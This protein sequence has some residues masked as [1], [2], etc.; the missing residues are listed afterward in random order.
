MKKLLLLCSVMLAA[1]SSLRAQDETPKPGTLKNPIVLEL[2]GEN[3][4]EF[5]GSYSTPVYKYT[6][7][8][9]QLVSVKP[10][11]TQ[12]S[13]K[14]TADGNAYGSQQLPS[15]KYDG[16]Y[17]FIV[18][19]DATVYLN[20]TTYSSPISLSASAKNHPYCLGINADEAIEIVADG[21]PMFVPFRE[22][23]YKE[24]PVYLKYAAAEDGALEMTFSGYVHEAY[25]AEGKNGKFS[26]ITCK[27]SGDNYRTFIPVEKGKEYFLRISSTSAKML[28]AELTHPVY[29]ES[30]D[31]P[32]VLTGTEA[33]I[34][35]KACKYYYEVTGT[36]SGY[37]VV[38]S[39]ISDFDGTVSWGRQVE[40]GLVTVDDG[41]FDLRQTATKGGHYFV[42]VD[43]KSDT[44]SPQ[45]FNVR[46]ETAQPYDSFYKGYEIA[47]GEE[48][49]LP[50]YP[51]TYFYRIKTPSEGAFIMKAAP[52]KA[53]T[54]TKS[55][56]RLFKAA[57]QSTPLYIG[58]PDIYCE[59]EAANEYI[60]QVTTVE[61]DKRNTLNVNLLDLQQGDGASNPFNV[62]IGGNN[63]PAG[64]A[65]YY[66]YK[67][68]KNSWVTVTPADMSINAPTVKRIKSELSSSEQNVTILRHGD[69]YRFEAETGHNYLLRFTK[70]KEATTFDFATPDYAQ[71]ESR[72]NPFEAEGSS[73]SIPAAPGV[74]WWSYTPARSGK[75]HISTDFKY[76]V[77]SSPTRENSVKLYSSETGYVLTTL[78]A[79]LT[80]ETF[81]PTTYNVD[82]GTKYLIQVSS[83]SEQSGKTVTLE[84]TDLDPGETPA[85]AIDI[86]PSSVP[87]EYP[88]EA[89]PKA[90][91]SARWYAIDLKE[92]ELSIYS[93]S[94]ISFYFYQEREDKT[95]DKS[96]YKYYA[97]TFWDSSYTNRYY[98]MKD[99][100][101][102]Q[103]GR[104]LIAAYY[105]YSDV[106]V[107]FEGTA[108]KATSGID[109][110]NEIAEKAYHIE[111]NIIFANKALNIYDLSGRI[112][113]NVA[114]SESVAVPAGIYVVKSVNSVTKLLIK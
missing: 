33:E 100:A 24:V 105:L 53:F 22:E 9:D 49:K 34:P 92:G 36:E 28:T 15:V 101:I 99:K 80:A 23:S 85:V 93:T 102:T 69:A 109:E 110:N 21:T 60:I 62:N 103:P 97:G 20:V 72:D 45:K 26:G 71:G 51:G 32:F 79:D 18:A 2:G 83:V 74:Y 66:L 78:V 77:V 82:E 7:P 61:E 95:Y 114:A 111:S 81:N 86:T 30:A 27:R 54:G 56:I 106:S 87:F 88:M 11:T 14:V 12:T 91:T 75:L 90:F 52:G 17:L 57:S 89:N 64:D 84:I 58:E 47:S 31:Y 98:G 4:Y 3:T 29:G 65:K 48:V 113:A 42:I 104:Y 37:G 16:S 38:S 50:P 73:I 13:I 94:S 6:A 112:V 55:D 1:T 40:S 68:T 59:V 19:K 63:L 108:L 67:A 76:D 39:D 10:N 44:P 25:Y 5:T 35:A 96:T 46:F 43:K 107:T 70:V 8:D 41:S